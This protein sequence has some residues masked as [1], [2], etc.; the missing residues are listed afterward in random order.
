[1]TPLRRLTLLAVQAIG[2]PPCNSGGAAR[3]H[4]KRCLIHG[5]AARTRHDDAMPGKRLLPLH[6][7]VC[8]FQSLAV[9]P[10]HTARTSGSFPMLPGSKPTLVL[11]WPFSTQG[12]RL[13]PARAVRL[14]EDS[15]LSAAP[16]LSDFHRCFLHCCIAVPDGILR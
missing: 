15:A 4:H 9:P 6:P 1:M 7:R 8:P 10:A 16:V 12:S 3:S 13:A 11:L 2:D 5:R 14:A